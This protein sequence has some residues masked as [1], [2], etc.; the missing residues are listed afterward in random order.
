MESINYTSKQGIYV[1][2]LYVQVKNWSHLQLSADSLINYNKKMLFITADD[3]YH[4]IHVLFDNLNSC[5]KKIT[6]TNESLK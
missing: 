1:V 3:N 4:G 2:V 5:K 6:F